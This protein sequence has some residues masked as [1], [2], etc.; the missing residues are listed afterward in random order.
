MNSSENYTWPM[1]GNA[2]A[3]LSTIWAQEVRDNDSSVGD[4]S[5]TLTMRNITT[6]VTKGYVTWNQTANDKEPSPRDILIPSWTTLHVGTELPNTWTQTRDNTSFFDSNILCPVRYVLVLVILVI[7]VVA[8]FLNIVALLM[9]VKNGMMT[10]SPVNYLLINLALV[11]LLNSTT[12]LPMFL[13]ALLVGEWP[14]Q[15]KGCSWY[16]FSFILY[17]SAALNT[18]AAIAMER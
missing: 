13:V 12:S 8:S 15:E 11:D 17:G 4:I 16:G 18:T 3:E 1:T 2:L 9:F 6:L 10:R 14:L 5:T 7:M